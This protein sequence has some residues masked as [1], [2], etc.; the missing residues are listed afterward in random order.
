M[1]GASRRVAA[2]QQAMRR[3]SN[4]LSPLA[5]PGAFR[6]ST[7]IKASSIFARLDARAGR[8]H[9]RLTGGFSVSKP[10]SAHGGAY[11]GD[12]RMSGLGIDSRNDGAFGTVWAAA[13]LAIAYLDAL[14]SGQSAVQ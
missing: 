5:L 1:A 6:T 3:R 2:V 13:R 9:G 11:Q 14:A 12:V 8:R 4:A 10:L 7:P